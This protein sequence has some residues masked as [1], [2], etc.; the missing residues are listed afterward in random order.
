MWT[1]TPLTGFSP[2]FVNI[3]AASPTGRRVN[4]RCRASNTFWGEH[5]F[6][7]VS[8]SGGKDHWSPAVAPGETVA[9]TTL[10]PYTVL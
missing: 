2:W 1:D 5:T 10:S 7:G 3:V 6:G 4:E 9:D 8:T